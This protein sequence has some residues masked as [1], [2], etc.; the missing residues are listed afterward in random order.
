MSGAVDINREIAP[1]MAIAKTN[2][3]GSID[4]AV[5]EIPVNVKESGSYTVTADLLL[6]NAKAGEAI[7]NFTLAPGKYSLPLHFLM[8][9]PLADPTRVR[10]A[11]LVISDNAT[12]FP[13]D[14]AEN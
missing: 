1:K 5:V 13:V 4:A 2:Q 11:N 3:E 10:L 8:P 7:E 14:L 6:G 12:G 9:V